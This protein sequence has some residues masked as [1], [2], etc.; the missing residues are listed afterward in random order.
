MKCKSF[1][2]GTDKKFDFKID[3]STRTDRTRDSQLAKSPFAA[4]TEKGP[5]QTIRTGSRPR[6]L[7]GKFI[8]QPQNFWRGS[9]T[10]VNL[11]QY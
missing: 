6:P 3:P 5:P 7:R 8:E 1:Y 2:T 4:L 11:A 10:S 9:K